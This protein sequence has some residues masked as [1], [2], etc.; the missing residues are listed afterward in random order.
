LT[1]LGIRE[2][3]DIEVV[4]IYRRETRYISD[5]SGLIIKIRERNR[6]KGL[7]L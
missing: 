7:A 6:E 1:E 3:Q 2:G 5:I 4:N